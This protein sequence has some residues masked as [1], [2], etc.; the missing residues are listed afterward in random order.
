MAEPSKYPLRESNSES[1]EI[2]ESE[3]DDAEEGMLNRLGKH[4]KVKVA[5]ASDVP[6]WLGIQSER[7]S[8]KGGQK[9]QIGAP[10]GVGLGLKRAK[11]T[12]H[13]ISRIPWL[14]ARCHE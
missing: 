8:N 7:E 12:Q 3:S 1:D 11:K 2:S 10:N 9:Y 6:V 13:M 4:R 14:K 5:V